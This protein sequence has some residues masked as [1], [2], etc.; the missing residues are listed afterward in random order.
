MRF[1]SNANN[2]LQLNRSVFRCFLGLRVTGVVHFY[3]VL[4]HYGTVF[5][6]ICG[7][8]QQSRLL[9]LGKIRFFFK[10]I[11]FFYHLIYC[12]LILWYFTGLCPADPFDEAV[13]DMITDTVTDLFYTLLKIH[14]EKDEAKKVGSCRLI[15]K[16]QQ[17]Q[18]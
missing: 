7:A 14:F 15:A 5:L 4:Q 1:R 6:L 3:P 18:D 16:Y 11:L 2:H 17:L 8:Q 12:N 9:K 10:H 13:A